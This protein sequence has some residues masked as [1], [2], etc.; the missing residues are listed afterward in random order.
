MHPLDFG[1]SISYFFYLSI[2]WRCHHGVENLID[3]PDLAAGLS[4]SER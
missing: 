3:L 2:F 1:G 4:R